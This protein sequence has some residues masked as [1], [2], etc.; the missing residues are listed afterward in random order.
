M[1]DRKVNLLRSIDMLSKTRGI[2]VRELSTICETMPIGIREQD[3]F[4][5][6]VLRIK[7]LLDPFGLQQVLLNIENRLGR[8]RVQ[9]WGPRMIDLDILFYSDE[10]I[11]TPNLKIPHPEIRNRPFVVDGLKELNVFID[12]GFRRGDMI[13]G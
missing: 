6:A 4:L 11:D 5:N 10:E 3:A 7:T 12:P 2:E 1:G 13:Y 8:V 9:R